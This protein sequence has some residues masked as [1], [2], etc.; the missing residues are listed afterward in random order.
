MNDELHALFTKLLENQDYDFS[1]HEQI[2]ELVGGLIGAADRM[3]QGLGQNPDEP[4]LPPVE[5][6]LGEV[7]AS[8]DTIKQMMETLLVA[9][10]NQRQILELIVRM[11]IQ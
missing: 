5:E 4:P 8:K 9:K 10:R 7:E 3:A 2:R 1:L 11:R 6:F